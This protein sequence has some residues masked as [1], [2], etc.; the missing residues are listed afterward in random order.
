MRHILIFTCSCALYLAG[1]S[2][3]VPVSFDRFHGFN[4]TENYLKEVVKAYP[5]ITELKV[6]G[7]SGMGRPLSVLIISNKTKLSLVR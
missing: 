4:G 3:K 1:F 6:I 2:Q 5:E 7:E